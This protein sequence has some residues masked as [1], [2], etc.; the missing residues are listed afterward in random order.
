MKRKAIHRISAILK[1]AQSLRTRRDGLENLIK[2]FDAKLADLEVEWADAQKEISDDVFGISISN[3][4]LAEE[5]RRIKTKRRSKKKT[6]HA[7]RNRRKL[8]SKRKTKKIKRKVKGTRD[9]IQAAAK[10][11]DEKLLWVLRKAKNPMSI[12]ELYKAVGNGSLEQIRTS[13]KRNRKKLKTVGYAKTTKYSLK[14]K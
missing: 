12:D 6:T 1:K 2:D 4:D 11:R 9:Q 5:M 13:L 7:F 10:A 3:E 14:R 8:K